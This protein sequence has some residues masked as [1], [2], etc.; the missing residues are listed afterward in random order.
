MKT[1]NRLQKS[2]KTVLIAFNA[3]NKAIFEY[4][5]YEIEV[6]ASTFVHSEISARCLN[7]EPIARIKRVASD[8]RMKRRKG[9]YLFAVASSFKFFRLKN[10]ALYSVAVAENDVNCIQ[11]PAV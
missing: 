1:K 7:S 2:Q 10:K 3:G 6:A 5:F 8:I 4:F 11:K 9:T